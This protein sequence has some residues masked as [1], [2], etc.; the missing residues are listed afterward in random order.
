MKML[1]KIALT[2]HGDY[3]H[4]NDN[5]NSINSFWRLSA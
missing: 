3:K 5:K 4:E 1:V 2:L